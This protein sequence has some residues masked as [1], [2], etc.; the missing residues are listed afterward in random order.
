MAAGA[1]GEAHCLS[2]TGCNFLRQRLVLAT[3]SGRP[4]KI[5]K[6]RSKEEDPGLRGEQRRRRPRGRSSGAA[7]LRCWL[8][9]G[10]AAGQGQTLTGSWDSPA[11]IWA[12]PTEEGGPSCVF[13]WMRSPLGPPHVHLGCS[14][15]T[16]VAGLWEEEEEEARERAGR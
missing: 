3:L 7:E 6:I 1:A 12:G 16:W 2:Y 15:H 5:R 4:L 8:C 10:P 11:S 13:P 14:C 9:P